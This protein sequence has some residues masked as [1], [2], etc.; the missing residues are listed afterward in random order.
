LTTERT[1]S[2]ALGD[3]GLEIH[4]M[5][6]TDWPDVKRIYEQGIGTRVATFDTAA[7]SWEDWDKAHRDECRFVARHGG[8]VVGWIALSAVSRRPVYRGV[9]ELSVY[10]AEEARGRGVGRALFEA[11]IPASEAAGIWT[12]QAGVMARNDAS[13]ALHERMGFRRVGVRQRMGRDVDGVWHDV[14]L[15]ERRSRV[16]G[17]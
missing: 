16:V 13:L 11:L 3:A 12:L 15:L 5:Q 2:R 9:A 4:P 17:T 7:P 14:V 6:P 8:R 1:A 10:V